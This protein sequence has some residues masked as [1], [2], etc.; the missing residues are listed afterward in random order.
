[1]NIIPLLHRIVVKPYDYKE[2][3]KDIQRAR[4]L[5]LEIPELEEMKRAQASVDQGVVVAIGP[6]AYR[7]YNT[8]VP[9]EVGDIVN[10]ARF[11][12]KLIEDGG[13]KLVILND[14]DLLCIV[15]GTHGN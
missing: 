13:E 11:A 6:T 1:M 10:Y 14:E 2:F 8:D 4:N 3:N 12:G 9:V 15:K 7:D 5:G